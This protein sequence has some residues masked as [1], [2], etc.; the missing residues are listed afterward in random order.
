MATPRDPP[1][2]VDLVVDLTPPKPD[3]GGCFP[4]TDLTDSQVAARVLVMVPNGYGPPTYTMTPPDIGYPVSPVR[5]LPEPSEPY[6]FY[7][8]TLQLSPPPA[9][10]NVT[11]DFTFSTTSAGRMPANGSSEDSPRTSSGTID[12]SGG[13]GGN[14]A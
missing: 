14:G 11:Y 12:V 10:S 7:L 6:D 2:E 9:S 1:P 4:V 8:F 3:S 5:F 13:P